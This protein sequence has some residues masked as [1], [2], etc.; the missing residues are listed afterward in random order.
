[1]SLIRP[2]YELQVKRVVPAMAAR[3]QAD[4]LENPLAKSQLVVIQEEGGNPLAKALQ[5]VRSG[6]RWVLNG[7]AVKEFKT[8]EV[9]DDPDTRWAVG[10][11]LR[12]AM[13]NIKT[14]A[15]A[16]SA[17][18]SKLGA[19]AEGYRQ[20]AELSKGD[21]IARECLLNMLLDGRLTKDKDRLGK[22]DLLGHLIRA[23]T[24]PL[25]PGLDRKDLIT[26]LIEEVDNPTKI[27]QEGKGTCVATSSTILFARETPTDYARLVV[28]L[29]MPAGTTTTA[30]GAKLT[31]NA[32]WNNDNDSG[33]TPS[34]RLLQ[35][36]LMELG[37][38][39]MRYNNAKD[40]H[41]LEAGGSFM[42]TIKDGWASFRGFLANIPIMPG[43]L[44]S[45]GA[46]KILQALT[47]D[48]YGQTFMVTRLNRES[49]FKRVE[50]ASKAGHT[51]PVGLEWEGG[52]HK[53]LLDKIADGKAYIT[54][55]WGQRETIGL[56]EFK[57]NLM[58]ANLPK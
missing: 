43:G 28:E 22:D 42:Q 23:A 27:S 34:V 37:N 38:G 13:D 51:V 31:R 5:A 50:A 29:A 56:A 39:W 36:A 19:R 4:P 53:V 8:R 44:S 58:D 7:P 12:A 46:K 57:S 35:P 15:A 2:A 49:T 11:Q 1:M 45:N 21:P 48:A 32:D 18:V 25:T 6:L 33:R 16:E 47:G 54:N 14:K 52:G 24:A 41:T 30:G 9:Y 55:P 10:P 26:S 20:L 40:V 3:V 17:A